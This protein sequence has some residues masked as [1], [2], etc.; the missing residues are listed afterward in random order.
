MSSTT[1]FFSI[2]LASLM[3]L[4]LQPAHA[5]DNISW[6]DDFTDEMQIGSDTYQYNFTRV[7]ENDCKMK[8]EELVTD[9]KGSTESRSWIFYLSDMNPSALSFKAKGKSINISMETQRSQKFITYYEEG[10]L[11]AYTED[12]EIKM[13][14]VDMARSFIEAVKENI[15]SCKETESTWENGEQALTWLVDNVGNAT[16]R[17]TNWDQK[18]K[19]GNQSYLV[20]FQANSE[21]QKGE[22][23]LSDYTFDLSD[24]DPKE[25]N[26]RISGTSLI[27]EV[28]VKEGKR[29]M[30]FTSPDATEFRNELSI[31]ADDIELARQIVNALSFLV[32]STTPERPKWD[33]YSASL[34]FVKD[35]LGEVTIGDETFSNSIDFEPSPAVQVDLAIGKSDNDGT[36]DHATN[37][38]YLADLNEK[39]GLEVSKSSITIE[40]EVKNGHDYI[41]KTVDDKVSD[42]SS[43]LGF[44][45]SEIDLARDIISALEHAIG[46]S[47]ENIVEFNDISEVSAWFSENIGLIEIDG[48]NYEQNLNTKTESENQLVFERKLTESDGDNT[49]TRYIIYPEDINLDELEIRV[50]GRKLSVQ[51][52]TVNAK[53]IKRFENGEL[54]SF[55]SNASVLFYDPLVA[56]NFIAAI[57]FLKGIS[58]NDERANMTMEEAVEFLSGNIQDIDLA[59]DQYVQKFEVVDYVN[60]KMKFSRVET[61]DKGASDELV[62]EFT[63]SDVHPGNSKFSVKGKLVEMNL[64]TRGNEKLIKPY[65][66]GEAGDFV[67]DFIIY[68]DDVLLAKKTLAA[69]AAI[70]EGCK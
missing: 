70:S 31:Y 65:K 22:Q 42:Y 43:S 51:L 2:L 30:K 21:N 46:N 19:P 23:Q 33:S 63:M 45:V 17:E 44:H 32:T 11:D 3:V 59:G 34:G 47:E 60:C 48:D 5:Q 41:R 27:V 36:T 64:V 66:N 54:Q 58:A 38:F 69:F 28:P 18:F 14:E 1:K 62:Y 29:Y 49:E 61:D 55:A 39:V 10:E 50:S 25:I 13:N 4:N 53:Y 20:D 57:R 12:I 8:F 56:K 16:E 9:K 7:E 15:A 24:I 40:M 26:L 35:N 37:S 52:E 68:A 67:D 6:L